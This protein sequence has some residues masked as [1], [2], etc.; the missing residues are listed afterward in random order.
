MLKLKKKYE[1]HIDTIVK[2]W[3][4]SEQILIKNRIV[5]LTHKEKNYLF[6]DMKSPH[7]F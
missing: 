6:F 7:K 1:K 2:L 4:I 5:S 3:L